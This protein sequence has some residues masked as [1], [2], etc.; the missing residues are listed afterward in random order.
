MTVRGKAHIAG[1]YEHPLREIPDKTV[2][3]IH[4][5]VAIGALADAGLTMADVDAYFGAGDTPGFGAL[6]MIEYLGISATYMDTT[7]MGGSSY[8]AHVNHAAAAIAAG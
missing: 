5:E 3:Q 7:E 6:S 4:A 1:V 8:V 2:P